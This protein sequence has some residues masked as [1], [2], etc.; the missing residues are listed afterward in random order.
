MTEINEFF[1]SFID[2]NSSYKLLPD[3]ETIISEA[4]KFKITD[5]QVDEIV[6]SLDG[7]LSSLE[8]RLPSQVSVRGPELSI[9]IPSIASPP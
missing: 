8:D 1:K 7:N 2:G 5:A 6:K 3:N 4:H 9:N